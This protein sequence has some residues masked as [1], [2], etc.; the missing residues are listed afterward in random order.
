[1]EYVF[2]VGIIGVWNM[3]LRLGSLECG[4]CFKGWDHWSVEYMFL[5]LGSLKWG[6]Y[7]FKV[8]IIG[9][10]NICL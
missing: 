10:G 8:G 2:N 7:V 3:F 9:V 6:I 5:R 4:I 1:M